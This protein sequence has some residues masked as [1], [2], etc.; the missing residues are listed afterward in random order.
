MHSAR[1][2]AHWHLGE[3]IDA[4]QDAGEDDTVSAVEELLAQVP[5]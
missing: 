1:T 5:A 4:L 3:A 2:D